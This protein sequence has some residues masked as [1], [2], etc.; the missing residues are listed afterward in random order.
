MFYEELSICVDREDMKKEEKLSCL[1]ESLHKECLT[2]F[3]DFKTC[4]EKGKNKNDC[5]SKL[6]E[7]FICV[8]GSIK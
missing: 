7:Y 2:A 5:N 6:G 1:K 4:I 8:D 3:V